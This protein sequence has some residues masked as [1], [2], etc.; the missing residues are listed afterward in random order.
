MLYFC[1]LLGWGS[2]RNQSR[3]FRTNANQLSYTYCSGKLLT[4][5]KGTQRILEVFL[6][7]LTAT[8][9]P[10]CEI[11]KVVTRRI[12]KKVIAATDI[13]DAR[14]LF[15]IWKQIYRTGTHY[16]QDVN[17]SYVSLRIWGSIRRTT[18]NIRHCSE[19]AAAIKFAVN[20]FI[21]ECLRRRTFFIAEWPQRNSP[22]V[23]ESVSKCRN[24]GAI[25]TLDCSRFEFYRAATVI[26]HR[27]QKV[28]YFRIV[29]AKEW[30][31]TE[32]ITQSKCVM[33]VIKGR[34]ITHLRKKSI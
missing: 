31:A 15:R 6:R 22:L 29:P 21:L 32:T 5:K 18:S 33:A 19:T 28:K 14:G 8:A 9:Y 23:Q 2:P 16:I 4:K 30:H 11:R 1:D 7:M 17:G 24:V 27:S 10:E 3:F 13:F 26:C 34:S 12:G 20:R 25:K